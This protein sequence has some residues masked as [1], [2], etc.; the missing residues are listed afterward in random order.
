MDPN[1]AHGRLVELSERLVQAEPEHTE[2]VTLITTVSEL[3]ETF[4]GLDDW[5]RSGGFLPR[6]WEA[7][8]KSAQASLDA[9]HHLMDGVEWNPGTLEATAEVLRASGFTIREP[10][11]AEDED[12]N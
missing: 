11:E 10:S 2:W 5:L 8:R 9:I 7:G 6:P 1:V 4:I 12:E 3:V